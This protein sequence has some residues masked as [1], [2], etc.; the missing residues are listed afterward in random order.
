MEKVHAQNWLL[1]PPCIWPLAEK[2]TAYQ[3]IHE[4]L[5]VL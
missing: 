1:G 3:L 5:S 4:K 2:K